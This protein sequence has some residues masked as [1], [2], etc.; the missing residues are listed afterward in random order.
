MPPK[1]RFSKDDVVLAAYEVTRQKGLEAVNARSVAAQIGCSTQ[2]LFR[3]FSCMEDIKKEVFL[4][5]RDCFDKMTADE[6]KKE[7]NTLKAQ[8]RVYLT[9]AKNEPNLFRM[10]FMHKR[11]E[12]CA[13][14][15]ITRACQRAA[16]YGQIMNVETDEASDTYINFWM[17][18]HGM[19]T[20][21]AT[22][23]LTLSDDVT[24]EVLDNLAS[25]RKQAFPKQ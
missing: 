8:G 19:A 4:H 10:L 22:G 25:S 6:I 11:N 21:F 3:E 9:L 2:P 14:F 12:E 5:A 13:N 15:A 20:M 1:I 7:E 23:Y 17:F 16:E 24:E 18:I